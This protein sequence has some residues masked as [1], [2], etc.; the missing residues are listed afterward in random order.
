MRVTFVTCISISSPFYFVAPHMYMDPGSWRAFSSLLNCHAYWNLN[1]PYVNLSSRW[2]WRKQYSWWRLFWLLSTTVCY[3]LWN[4]H[5]HHIFWIGISPIYPRY[6]PPSSQTETAPAPDPSTAHSSFHL[7]LTLAGSDDMYFFLQM[8]SSR[9]PV[10]ATVLSEKRPPAKT[11][12]KISPH[13]VAPYFSNHVQIHLPPHYCSS[14]PLNG[15]VACHLW[16]LFT[17]FF[18]RSSKTFKSTRGGMCSH[19]LVQSNTSI[20]SSSVRNWIFFSPR[21][22]KIRSGLWMG[23][24]K[25][26][27][28][29]SG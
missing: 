19:S 13:P 7:F 5:T 18:G 3:V 12:A 11:F 4:A 10:K 21:T 17:L 16:C 6:Q 8:L 26:W 23:N 15:A 9:S 24:T 20:F 28:I 2:W 25:S 1:A 14:T 22:C 29:L 27:F